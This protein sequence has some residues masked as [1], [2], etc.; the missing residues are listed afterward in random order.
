[1]CSGAQRKNI[2]LDNFRVNERRDI[3]YE[4]HSVAASSSECV[5][6]ITLEISPIT[7]KFSCCDEVL[8][9]NNCDKAFFNESCKLENLLIK[10]QN[11][12][13][14]RQFLLW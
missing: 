9:E 14:T 10:N 11:L 3:F 5:I 13:L 4:L 6:L 8:Q 12:V 1:M 2:K 7:T